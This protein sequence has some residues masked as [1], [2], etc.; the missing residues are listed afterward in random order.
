MIIS[1]SL[2]GF[3]LSGIVI[4][5]FPRF[6]SQ[7]RAAGQMSC[8]AAIFALTMLL[9]LFILLNLPIAPSFSRAGFMV[10]AF[11]YI[12]NSLPFFFAGLCLALAFSNLTGRISTL[13]FSDL[14][15]AGV[16]CLLSIPLLNS[17]GAPNSVLLSGCL[18]SLA[19]WFFSLSYQSP[20]QGQQVRRDLLRRM[21]IMVILIAFAWILIFP[22]KPLIFLLLKA[23]YGFLPHTR[24]FQD[25][26]YRIEPLYYDLA[27][28]LRI[29][30]AV[31]M[32]IGL[33][34]LLVIIRFRIKKYPQRSS[35]YRN[36]CLLPTAAL[37][38]FL[39]LL[40]IQNVWKGELDF[41]FVRGR[42]L[43]ELL[44]RK[45]NAL[46]WVI[47]HHGNTRS[48][49]E[50]R[51]IGAWGMSPAYTGPIVD[52]YGL[53][54]DAYAGTPITKFDGDLEKVD[55][56]NYDIPA[57]VY[58][59]RSQP[60]VLIIGAGGGIDILAALSSGSR[61]VT[62]IEINPAVVEAMRGPFREYSGNVYNL[63]GVRAEVGEGR[64][65]IR[66]SEEE[67]DV[68]QISMV[69]TLAAA[70]S[71]AYA[72]SENNLYTV[73]AF[74]EYLNHLSRDGIFTMSRFTLQSLR[75]VAL[76]RA[77]MERI[78]IEEPARHI[79]VF[80]SG[81]I[82]NLLLKRSPFTDREVKKIEE[83]AG[84]LKFKILYTP[85]TP[86]DPDFARLISTADPELFY[87]EY[88]FDVTPT[89]DNKPFFFQTMRPRDFRKIFSLSDNFMIGNQA[90]FSL[91]S[92]LVIVTILALFFL[93]GPLLLFKRKVLTSKPRLRVST[94]LYF[95]SIGLAFMLLE[96]PLIQMFGLFLGHPTYSLSVV[97]F[98]LL[99]SC[100]V[101]SF[102]TRRFSPAGLL[103]SL[104]NVIIGIGIWAILGLLLLPTVF[105]RFLDTGLP[106]RILLSLVFLIP[107]GLVMGMAFPV[108]IK[109]VDRKW[110]GAIPWFWGINGAASVM[111]SAWALALSISFGFR[112]T[113]I[114]SIVVYLLALIFL[115]IGLRRRAPSAED[116]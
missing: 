22:G 11:L 38:V 4:Y 81:R 3:G 68:I 5:L 78:G 106:V 23:I 40:V 94:L 58:N 50:K 103:Q 108:G 14:I 31:G 66:R 60:K 36:R 49:E 93:L 104:R 55:F 100:G 115:K 62:G 112:M 70:S 56:V 85:L 43:P 1:L 99:I 90:V 13:Y 97:L 102:L 12:L 30:M 89:T 15:G 9:V 65:F 41:R 32:A 6:F 26:L 46:S 51:A 21:I 29:V 84:R 72:L 80:E 76:A 77:A 75:T 107:L 18:A 25:N 17:I 45:W 98:S 88:P 47:V 64:N 110:H 42:K 27:V 8:A 109:I 59:I 96:I 116:L 28:Y 113:I 71:G 24:S 2:F 95:F 67:Y 105:Y 101:G 7:E 74:T 37:V 73:E 82:G 16:G 48:E 79:M 10:L 83:V 39:V 35:W 69:D 44:Y 57:L 53:R 63:P 19:A 87:R 54:I 34:F 91:V 61:D 33:F 52:Q 20:D 92:V 86:A 111:G 114:I